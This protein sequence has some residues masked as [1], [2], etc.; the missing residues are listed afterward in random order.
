MSEIK[1]EV[2][3]LR[4]QFIQIYYQG[5]L[6]GLNRLGGGNNTLAELH[7]IALELTQKHFYQ[8]PI[9]QSELEYFLNQNEQ[10]RI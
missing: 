6:D 3:E 8:Y 1:S 7:E 10:N 5:C 2:S 9:Y 4:L